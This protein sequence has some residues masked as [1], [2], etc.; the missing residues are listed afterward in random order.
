MKDIS[1]YLAVFCFATYVDMTGLNYAASKL[2]L[3]LLTEMFL[4]KLYFYSVKLNSTAIR[5][6]FPT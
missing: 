5:S 4:I 1:N 3:A 6:Y 2:E